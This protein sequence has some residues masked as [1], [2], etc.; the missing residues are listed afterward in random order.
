MTRRAAW[1]LVPLLPAAL[2]VGIYL[3]YRLDPAPGITTAQ[4]TAVMR[5]LRGALQG[6]RGAPR[7]DA[8]LALPGPLWVTLFCQ[9]HPTS[10]QRLDAGDLAGR[11]TRA[12]EHLAGSSWIYRW[13]AAPSSPRCRC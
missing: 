12:A 9:G 13:P 3:R 6:Q 4:A 2:Y 8:G 5:H 1:L 11:A 10:R 7:V